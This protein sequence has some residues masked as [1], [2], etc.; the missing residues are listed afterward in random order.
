MTKRLL[1]IAVLCFGV[2]VS[3][4]A[5]PALPDEATVIRLTQAGCQFIEPEGENHGFRPAN[6]T[7]CIDINTRT[8]KRRLAASDVMRLKPGAYVFRVTNSNVP[9]DIGFY[10]RSASEV[11]V[12]FKPSVMGGGIATGGSRDYTVRLEEGEY[13]FSCP[14]NPTPNYRLVVKQ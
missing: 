11:L 6:A 12:P 7:D 5:G 8:S 3:V 14:L 1:H 2:T 13:V 10:L 9:Y 4:L